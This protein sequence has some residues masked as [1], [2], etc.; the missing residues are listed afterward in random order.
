MRRAFVEVLV[1]LRAGVVHVAVMVHQVAVAQDAREPAV[2]HR[3]PERQVAVKVAFGRVHPTFVYPA[4]QVFRVDSQ[5]TPVPPP[6]GIQGHP[7]VDAETLPGTPR[8]VVSVAEG[9]VDVAVNNTSFVPVPVA[10]A[11]GMVVKNVLRTC[12]RRA[13]QPASPEAVESMVAYDE[14]GIN[15]DE[16]PQP[17]LPRDIA[18]LDTRDPEWRQYVHLR[19][20]ARGRSSLEECIG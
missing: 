10:Q 18:C 7:P 16:A 2:H 14:L 6:P 3:A 9:A 8:L 11:A 15:E 12:A 13:T 1:A 5:A 20:N 4:D 17:D 19:P